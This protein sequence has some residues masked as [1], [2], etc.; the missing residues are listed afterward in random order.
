MFHGVAQLPSQFCQIP[1]NLSIIGQI[2]ELP[3]SKSS[4]S[5]HPRTIFPIM[6]FFSRSCFCVVHFP[7]P[8]FL[9][10]TTL[11]LLQTDCP[12]AVRCV[13]RSFC[14]LLSKRRNARTLEV[15]RFWRNATTNVSEAMRGTFEKSVQLV[16][17]VAHR[18]GS[19]ERENTEY[20]SF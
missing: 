8:L 6:E 19:K 7:I 12:L 10:Q 4:K 2:S 11:F 15:D 17:Q 3:K 16:T 13:N 1:I 5:T 14:Q 20:S 9:L 18:V